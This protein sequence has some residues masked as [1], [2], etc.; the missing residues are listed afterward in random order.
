MTASLQNRK[1][2][3]S[4]TD[5]SLVDVALPSKKPNGKT[6][7]ITSCRLTFSRTE[8][9]NYLIKYRFGTTTQIWKELQR[10]KLRHHTLGDLDKLRQAGLVTSFKLFSER[11]GNNE[12]CWLITKLGVKKM[13]AAYTSHYADKP[14]QERIFLRD[15]ELKLA[16]T[17]KLAGWQFISPVTYSPSKPMPKQTSQYHKLAKAIETIEAAR[18]RAALVSGQINQSSQTYINYKEQQHL[19]SVPGQLNDYVAYIDEIPGAVIVLML[20]PPNTGKKA[21]ETRLEKYSK[22]AK[23]LPVYGVFADEETKVIGQQILNQVAKDEKNKRL[24]SGYGANLKTTTLDVIY[25]LL[26]EI[27]AACENQT[28]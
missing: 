7:T 6:E 18:V 15:M 26:D 12:L 13:G 2:I 9:L 19:W 10:S 8:I 3:V 21:W 28:T 25:D 14:S 11:D 22:V 5:L 24:L 20:C 4:N 27:A 1:P 16:R 23:Y 17:I